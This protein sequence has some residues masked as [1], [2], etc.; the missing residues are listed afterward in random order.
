M[1]L[2][3]KRIKLQE[4]CRIENPGHRL[5]HEPDLEIPGATD[6]KRHQQP[7]ATDQEH[8]EREKETV[9]AMQ[10]G[11]EKAHNGQSNRNQGNPPG[12]QGQV[13]IPEHK[14][15]GTLPNSIIALTGGAGYFCQ[16][17]G[18][19]SGIGSMASV[20]WVAARN[21]NASIMSI[22]ALRNIRSFSFGWVGLVRDPD[23]PIRACVG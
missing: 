6:V 4:D 5:G 21:E 14:G 13:E 3:N 12:K 11:R 20:T 1:A 15:S 8:Q 22:R 9:Y 23:Y 19:H 17:Q 10:T 16:G 18:M 7:G 2:Q